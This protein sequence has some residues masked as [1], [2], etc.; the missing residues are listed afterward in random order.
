MAEISEE[1]K[2]L[3]AIRRQRQALEK[4]LDRKIVKGMV[5]VDCAGPEKGKKCADKEFKFVSE[6]PKE[7]WICSKCWMRKTKLDMERFPEAYGRKRPKEK[8][9]AYVDHLIR[10]NARYYVRGPDGENVAIGPKGR[11]LLTKYWRWWELKQATQENVPDGAVWCNRLH[12]AVESNGVECGGCHQRDDCVIEAVREVA[13]RV[14]K[15]KKQLV[16]PKED[17][18]AREERRL[19]K[20]EKKEK[21]R[22][23]QQRILDRYSAD[24]VRYV[25]GNPKCKVDLSQKGTR[26]WMFDGTRWVQ[27]VKDVI[28]TQGV[29]KRRC[30]DCYG[31][32]RV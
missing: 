26:F 27:Q 3:D 13:T 11:P 8:T 14:K 17:K 9:K 1:R 4:M 22:S 2:A 28:E 12:K 32:G 5:R 10:R 19:E 6:P 20:E 18:D 30:C 7:R 29:Q 23:E 16:K 31:K 24:V 25:C 21:V 15:L